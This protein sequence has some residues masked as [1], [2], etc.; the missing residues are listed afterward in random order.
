MKLNLGCGLKKREGF[1]NIDINPDFEPDRILDLNVTPYPFEDNSC[2][3]ILA[4][5]LLEH[6]T[7]HP[8]DFFRECFRILKSDGIL[9]FTTPNMFTVRRKILYL[10]GKIQWESGWNP[11]HTKLVHPKDLMKVLRLVGFDPTY[12]KDYDRFYYNWF[13]NLF[14]WSIHVKAR[15]RR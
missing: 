4:F 8:I 1:I 2:E 14:G 3:Y 6:L 12:V 15:K 7:I 13:P 10:L 5:E 9:E 11:Y